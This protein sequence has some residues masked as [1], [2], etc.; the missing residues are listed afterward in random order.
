[1]PS[2]TMTPGETWGGLASGDF[3]FDEKTIDGDPVLVQRM[4]LAVGAATAYIGDTSGRL[5]D[6]DASAAALFVDDRRDGVTISAT[7][8]V[9]TSPAYIPKD[10][11]GSYMSFANAVRASGGV[12]I[13][14]QIQVGDLS[15]LSPDMDLVFFDRDISATTTAGDNDPFD[16]ADADIGKVCGVIPVGPSFYSVFAD[17]GVANIPCEL[18]FTLN[19][20]TT[21]HG[22]FVCRTGVTLTGVSDLSCRLQIERL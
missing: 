19:A 12:G 15:A 2:V 22:L 18:E 21:L 7:P 5:V 8:V 4:N 3:A 17:N 13:I 20:T 11:M 14:K 9:S 6:G 1:M 16:L 10:C